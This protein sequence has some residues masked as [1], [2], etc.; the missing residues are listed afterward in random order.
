MLTCIRTA[1]SYEQTRTA[2]AGLS[3]RISSAKRRFSFESSSRLA[4]RREAEMLAGVLR[5]AIGSLASVR[6]AVP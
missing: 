6:K 4:L 2:T 5:L 1:S 3:P